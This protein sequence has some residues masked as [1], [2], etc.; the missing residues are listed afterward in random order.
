MA[1]KFREYNW[2]DSG[3]DFELGSAMMIASHKGRAGKEPPLTLKD[4]GTWGMHGGMTT[5][6]ALQ[7]STGCLFEFHIII[8]QDS[9]PILSVPS[10][11]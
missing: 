10:R 4:G 8:F 9:S 3:H 5:T 11:F 2:Q 6:D 1:W 7:V